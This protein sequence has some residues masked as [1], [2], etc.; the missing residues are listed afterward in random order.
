MDE[1][2]KKQCTLSHSDSYEIVKKKCGHAYNKGSYHLPLVTKVFFPPTKEDND[3]DQDDKPPMSTLQPAERDEDGGSFMED[4]ITEEE[5]ST[6]RVRKYYKK[7]PKKVKQYLRATVDDRTQRNKDRAAAVEKHGEKKMANHDVHHPDGPDG[8][9][10]Q[11]AKKDHGPDKKADKAKKKASKSAPKKTEKPA[12]KAPKQAKKAPKQAKK[13][14]YLT[15]LL[16]N[17]KT[18]K[19]VLLATALTYPPNHPL[20]KAAVEFIRLLMLAYPKDH[21][22][23]KIAVQLAPHSK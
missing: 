11:L 15:H 14:P 10:W 7:H 13:H 23:Y 5:T 9:H 12:K 18:A 22:L 19:D 21:E 20:H 4:M 6:A 2:T 17:P 16:Q 3:P 8:G 1:E